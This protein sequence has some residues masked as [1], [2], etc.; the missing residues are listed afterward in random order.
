[1]RIRMIVVISVVVVVVAF[2]VSRPHK[3]VTFTP[4]P[5]TPVML[6]TSPLTDVN[7]TV[8]TADARMQGSYRGKYKG[9]I[10]QIMLIDDQ[11]YLVQRSIIPESQTQASSKH[12]I[13]D[14]MHTTLLELRADN[15]K[16]RWQR[17]IVGSVVDI[18]PRD[19]GRISMIINAGPDPSIPANK[20]DYRLLML[21]RTG[22]PIWSSRLPD[23]DYL[24]SD[25][26]NTDGDVLIFSRGNGDSDRP[27][28]YLVLVGSD[29]RLMSHME[30]MPYG[31]S[32]LGK[33]NGKFRFVK[34][35]Y[36][37]DRNRLRRLSKV[38]MLEMDRF[39]Q[40][41]KPVA[42]SVKDG[43][44]G[45]Q[46]IANNQ[47]LVNTS[48]S[49]YVTQWMVNNLKQT[50][51]SFLPLRYGFISMDSTNPDAPTIAFRSDLAEAERDYTEWAAYV[52]KTNPHSWKL[53][54]LVS[55][56][57]YDVGTL[58][59]SLYGSS[60]VL[61]IAP[62]EPDSWIV[63]INRN[64]KVLARSCVKGFIQYPV[65]TRSNCLVQ[66]SETLQWSSIPMVSAPLITTTPTADG[67]RVRITCAT[68]G[69]SIRYSVDTR[70][71][72]SKGQRYRG[73]FTV[74]KGSTIT[75]RATAPRT[76]P[77]QV[78]EVVGK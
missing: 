61:I 74:P 53:R 48:T 20:D 70:D 69:A 38:Q 13:I 3:T 60:D 66:M 63:L 45:H 26:Q 10:D 9:S 51:H 2:L 25:I 76:L 33:Q 29:G 23:H 77:S 71:P 52:D 31:Y 30:R 57:F 12:K 43:T 27:F 18:S 73:E 8:I 32:L 62:G 19:N 7:A 78:V 15:Q 5:T 59:G 49:A 55:R 58:S 17:V 36:I 67:L 68:K 54:P 65:I 16:V 35:T 6:R 47:L 72:D 39:G 4:I 56:S 44:D 50:Y 11:H 40:F 46:L 75:A 14:D 22:H 64:G 42:L 41:G 28:G 34:E 24:G 1:M 21:D 37:H